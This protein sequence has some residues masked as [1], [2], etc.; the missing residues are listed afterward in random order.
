MSNELQQENVKEDANEKDVVKRNIK[1][2]VFTD[3]FGNKKYL[4]ELYLVLH[5]EDTDVTEDDLTD[6]TIENVLVNDLYNDLG[7]KVGSRLI[8]LV[9]AQSSW[10]P[11]ILIRAF[12]YIATTYQKYIDERN[13]DLYTSK[14]VELP[15]PE[16]A[17]DF[18]QSCV[19]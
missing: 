7:F 15:K 10:S 2:C 6:I 11:N 4:R 14:K 13:L 5:P 3:L 18:N 9:E 16:L 17:V 1:D 19:A 12:L 8:I